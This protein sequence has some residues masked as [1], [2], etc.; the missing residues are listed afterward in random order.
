MDFLKYRMRSSPDPTKPPLCSLRDLKKS[1]K[2]L[3]IKPPRCRT[4]SISHSSR[5]TSASPSQR[6][7]IP[8]S[9]VSTSNVNIPICLQ[10]KLMDNCQQRKILAGSINHHISFDYRSESL[11]RPSVNTLRSGRNDTKE[12]TFGSVGP[13]KENNYVDIYCKQKSIKKNRKKSR[14]I[15]SNCINQLKNADESIGKGKGKPPLACEMGSKELEK[16]YKKITSGL[17]KVSQEIEEV[18]KNS[19]C[20]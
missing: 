7:C 4:N 10:K 19:L 17:D 8:L 6:P 13:N 20:N 14:D 2:D 11:E 9:F 16:R 15:V 1:Q 3:E 12:C 5:T 18:L